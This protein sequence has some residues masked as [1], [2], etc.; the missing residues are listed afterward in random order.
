MYLISHAPRTSDSANQT[1]SGRVGGEKR[2]KLGFTETSS[3]SLLAV[4]VSNRVVCVFVH[5]VR[6]G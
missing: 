2:L 1:F 6:S 3:P 5:F 4:A